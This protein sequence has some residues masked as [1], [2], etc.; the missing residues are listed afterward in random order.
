MVVSFGESMAFLRLYFPLIFL[1]IRP[2]LTVDLTYLWNDAAASSDN[3]LW[4]D[5]AA[6]SD[7]SLWNDA[8]A[9]SDNSLWNDAVASSDNFFF[10]EYDAVCSNGV[11][12]F[13][14][15]WFSDPDD[16][17]AIFDEDWG[18][19]ESGCFD[20]NENFSKLRVRD[21]CRN[22][23]VSSP[24]APTLPELEDIEGA[25]E[26]RPEVGN[27]NE[28]EDEEPIEILVVAE[29]PVRPEAP[30][31]VIKSD[32]GR[33]ISE[34][35]PEYFCHAGLSLIPFFSPIFGG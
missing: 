11:D 3:S 2:A 25:V 16:I 13:D 7:N 29:E 22:P 34:S 27:E 24:T 35:E 10:P 33:D 4:N 18:L 28:T 26:E 32:T 6:S 14:D 1:V 30:F 21:S 17:S 20:P 15:N 5:A 12:C 9:S 19:A 23:W 8:V 31:Q